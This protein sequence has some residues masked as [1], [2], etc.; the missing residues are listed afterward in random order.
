MPVPVLIYKAAI[1]VSKN[2]NQCQQMPLNI[3][4][5]SA[6]MYIGKSQQ[7]EVSRFNWLNK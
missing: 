1:A 7:H 5:L 3:S 4:C 6:S 2:F